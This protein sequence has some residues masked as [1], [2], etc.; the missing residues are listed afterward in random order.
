[1]RQTTSPIRQVARGAFTLVEMLVV[2]AIIF[3]LVS[4]AAGAIMKVLTVQQQHVTQQTVQ[5]LDGALNS[6]LKSVI[7]TAKAEAPQV[8]TNPTLN[9]LAWQLSG[10]DQ[11]RAQ[12]I[13]VLMCL[14]REFPNSFSEAVNP[15]PY[16]QQSGYSS[17]PP[18]PSYVRAL[19]NIS[20]RAN[21][22][23]EAS[24][25]LYLALKQSRRGSNF[26]PDSALSTAE[27]VTPFGD[28][29]KEIYDAW[30]RPINFI[31]WPV[32][33]GPKMGSVGPYPVGTLQSFPPPPQRPNPPA[34]SEDP[35]LLLVDANWLKWLQNTPGFMLL[36][37]QN[38]GYPL[39]SVDNS[40]NRFQYA[41]APLIM[42]NGYNGNPYD[43]DDIYNIQAR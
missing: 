30:S 43:S 11:R 4:L 42:S 15:F 3:I 16:Y 29:V 12:V 36:W 39:G 27:L 14:K 24:S 20:N 13:H 40:G 25:C 28:G 21:P 26:D 31:R 7:D 1:M 35:E 37:Q 18:N 19:T 2:L 8:P 38:V 34:D 6:H 23:D 17:M 5:K 32:T 22:V 9:P 10:N 33:N 41:L